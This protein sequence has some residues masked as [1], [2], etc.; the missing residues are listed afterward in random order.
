MTSETG[1]QEDLLKLALEAHTQSTLAA[2]QYREQIRNG[3]IMALLTV[4]VAQFMIIVIRE[5]AP[6]NIFT[7][8]LSFGSILLTL[9]V[10][11]FMMFSFAKSQRKFM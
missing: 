10:G 8:V 9:L 3:L 5:S 2:K 11:T 4:F 1:K 7:I 6:E